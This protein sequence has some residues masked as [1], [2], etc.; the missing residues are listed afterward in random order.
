MENINKH[1]QQLRRVYEIVVVVVF[2]MLFSWK[3]MKIIFYIFIFDI[4]I[5]K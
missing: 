1:K 4:N 2:K 3:Y 5:S